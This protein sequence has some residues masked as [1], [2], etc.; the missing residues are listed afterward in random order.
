MLRTI[1][2]TDITK[3]Q[4]SENVYLLPIASKKVILRGWYEEWIKTAKR[5]HSY[6]EDSAT[7]GHTDQCQRGVS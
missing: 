3:E 2:E 4:T 1:A 6:A 7:K 5:V